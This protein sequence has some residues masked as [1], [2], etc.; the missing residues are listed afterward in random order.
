[1]YVD[2]LSKQ[3]RFVPLRPDGSESESEVVN[4]LLQASAARLQQ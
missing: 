2:R 3:I 1:M 4:A